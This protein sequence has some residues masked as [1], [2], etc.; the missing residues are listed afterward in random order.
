MRSLGTSGGQTVAPVAV[1]N[2][3]GY[4]NNTK[5]LLVSVIRYQTQFTML[6][7]DT[8]DCTMVRI[9]DCGL[10]TDSV[11]YEDDEI[12]REQISV[13]LPVVGQQGR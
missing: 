1:E 5:N 8:L 6:E 11:S 10:D 3:R 4:H 2:I 12:K 7:Q 9:C 13:C